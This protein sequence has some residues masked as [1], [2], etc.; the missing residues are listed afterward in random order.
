MCPIRWLCLTSVMT[1][2]ILYLWSSSFWF[3]KYVGI[4]N[5]CQLKWDKNLLIDILEE[6]QQNWVVMLKRYL[7]QNLRIFYT[8]IIREKKYSSDQLVLRY[9][10]RNTGIWDEVSIY[11]T[12]VSFILQRFCWYHWVVFLCCISPF[13]LVVYGNKIISWGWSLVCIEFH[14]EATLISLY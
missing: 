5:I 12:G 10:D 6:L 8:H 11:V 1:V 2:F 4:I 3:E 7:H 9:R 13:L 14:W